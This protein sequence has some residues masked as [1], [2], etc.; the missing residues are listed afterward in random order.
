MRVHAELLSILIL[1]VPS[2][3]G[4]EVDDINGIRI[5]VI[6]IDDS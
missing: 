6:E 1:G 3:V 5:N 4:L 2:E